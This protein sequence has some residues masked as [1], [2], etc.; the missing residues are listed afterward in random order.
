MIRRTLQDRLTSRA[1]QY[2]AVFL[3]GP[4]Q[5]GKT[6]LSRMAFPDFQYVSLESM[7]NREE[8]QEDPKGFL[9]RLSSARGVILDE[10]QRTPDLFSELQGLLD[11]GQGGP[12]ILTGSQ[13]FLLN[14]KISQTLA[15]RVAI[16]E[17]LPFSLAELSG[18]KGKKPED[19]LAVSPDECTLDSPLNEA[20]FKGS[21]PRIHDQ[22]LDPVPWL[23]SYIQ[24]Y[25]ERDVRTLTNIGDLD[26][27]TRF[28]GLCA[29]RAGSLLNLSSLGSDAGIS[30]V[31]AKKWLSILQAGYVVHLL[32]PHH[33]N[34]GKRLV[35]SPKLYFT[36]AGLLC[37]LLGI[38]SPGD[39][40]SHPLRG[41]I[42]ENLVVSEIRKLFLN[43]GERPPIWFW[44]DSRGR[45]VDLLIDLGI[46]KIPLEAKAGLTVP[47]DA[48]KGLDHYGRIS[49]H[50]GGVLV[51][52]GK[53]APY[54]RKG[55][56][57][58]S[59]QHL[60]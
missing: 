32:R 44:R 54:L 17:L 50:P 19:I 49:G 27:F 24:T 56:T 47:S 58:R 6:T 38:R 41:V 8:A 18:R 60:S 11:I 30:H 37:R 34:F 35:R 7:Q 14:E 3:T 28:L 55:Y 53:S 10:V 25:V 33:E 51:H 39:L 45:E 43:R 9:Q 46:S 4:R 29:G 59:W 52:G 2:P 1:R 36:D 31:T 57:V 22:R 26:A 12:W 15:G 5:S 16:L 20:L 42:F 48:F 40:Q 23:D 13:Q 21:F